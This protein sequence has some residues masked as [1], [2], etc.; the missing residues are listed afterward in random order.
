MFCV[1][2]IVAVILCNTGI[3]LLAY[4]DGVAKTPTLGSVVMAASGSA[5][6]AIY[7]VTPTW[8]LRSHTVTPT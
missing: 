7:K 1:L 6:S 2:Q 4:M 8:R 5:C 3:A